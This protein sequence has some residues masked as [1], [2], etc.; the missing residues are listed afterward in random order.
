MISH[1]F[2]IKPSASSQNPDVLMITWRGAT[3]QSTAEIYLPAVQSTA[4]IA[5]ADK[6]YGKHR[7]TATDANTIQFPAGDLTLIPIPTGGAS[8]AGLLSVEVQPS[9]A[10]GQTC[11][12]S[13]RQ[14]NS[15]SATSRTPPPPPPPPKIA[16][17]KSARAKAVS[18]SAR[19]KAA[20]SQVG[21]EDKFYW[22]EVQ[23][24][25]QYTITSESTKTLLPAQERLLGWLKWRIGITPAK[26]HWL[27]VLQRY[28]SYTEGL[29]WNLG[30]DPNTIP[31]SQV[32]KLPGKGPGPGPK[33]PIWQREE[34]EC[35][36][37]VVAIRYDRFG[38]FRGFVILTE[39]GHDREFFATEY[40]IEELVRDA[41]VERTVITVFSD[42]H[43]PDRPDRIIL[44]RYH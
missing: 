19:A 15:V 5:L 4:I 20:D 6:I 30:V 11:T 3:A 12:V 39:S 1:P 10:E 23:G 25:F 40:A 38:D 16:V 34:R 28:L 31:P 41:W 7:L 9:M 29:V 14:L 24:A 18:K 44:K 13:V 35:T 43:D 21:T 26:N 27:P 32:G 17:S 36:G 22:R 37:K 2:E 42:E 33:P 8:F